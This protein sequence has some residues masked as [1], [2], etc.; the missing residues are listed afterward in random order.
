MSETN[1]K[2]N[3]YP[4]KV[5][6]HQIFSSCLRKKYL[7]DHVLD[8]SKVSLLHLTWCVPSN[9]VILCCLLIIEKAG[10]HFHRIYEANYIYS[11]EK[12]K[13]N[14]CPDHKK[15]ANAYI[16]FIH[17]Y[18]TLHVYTPYTVKKNVT[19][20]TFD[21]IFEMMSVWCSFEKTS[22]CDMTNQTILLRRQKP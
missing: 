2:T 3:M 19:R 11:Q 10:T 8:Y 22:N 1:Q 6:D 14:N 4:C 15:R 16:N 12:E 21:D 5:F 7:H 13:K 18:K 17:S 9:P 20:C